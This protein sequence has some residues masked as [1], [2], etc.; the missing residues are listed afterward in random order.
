M[1]L[2]ISFLP[3][4][5]ERLI[6]RRFTDADLDRFYSYRQDPDVA[7]Y[8]SW[9]DLSYNEAKSFIGDMH[10]AAIG[11]P[12]EW[13]QIAIAHKLSNVLVG[14]IGM[15][16]KSDDPTQ[17]EIGFTLDAQEHGKGY[18]Q[19]A[20][21]ALIDRLFELGTITKIVGITDIRNQPS[22]NLLTRVGMTLVK[23]DEVEFNGEWCTEQTFMLN[24]KEW[25]LRKASQ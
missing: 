10:N 21:Q 12:G 13:F 15:H 22:I 6:L 20:V 25:L 14:D 16:V 23:S 2:P 7:R 24:K 4:V 9:S 3:H 18:A 17:V 11:I 8:Q 5:T 1:P 19:E